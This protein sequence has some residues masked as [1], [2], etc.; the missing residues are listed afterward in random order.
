[1]AI[2]RTVDLSA[3]SRL[4]KP[5]IGTLVSYCEVITRLTGS[6]GIE[7]TL[8]EGKTLLGLKLL[9]SRA[10]REAGKTVAYRETDEGTL[11]VRLKEAKR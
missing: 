7:L 4:Q 9:V 2:I 6:S 1:M 11:L 5:R 8:E 3:R 10:A